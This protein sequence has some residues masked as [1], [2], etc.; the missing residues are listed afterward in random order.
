MEEI[1][2]L[3]IIKNKDGHGTM[4]YKIALPSKWIKSM[5]LD[6]SDY[7]TLIFKGN[8]IIIKNKEDYKMEEMIKELKEELLNKEFKLYE[9]DNAI[10]KIT[11]S[12]TSICDT[13]ITA[14][15]LEQKSCAYYIEEDKEIIVEFEILEEDDD[16]SEI[17]VKVTDFW[18]N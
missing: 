13:F 11:D 6:K 1:R 7:A 15:C 3:K 12:G 4:G 17:K 2:D 9:M 5:G 18:E 14:D 16:P 8:S 10:K